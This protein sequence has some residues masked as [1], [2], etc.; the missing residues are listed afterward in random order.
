MKLS[1]LW[2]R[3]GFFLISVA[4]ILI[5]IIA[6][7]SIA[8]AAGTSATIT[9]VHPT[10][11]IDGSALA[12]SDIKETIITWRRPGD[13]TVVGSTRVPGPATTTVVSGL[14]C[15]S[16]NFTAATVVQTSSAETAPAAY[17]TG[18]VCAPNPPTG[19]KVT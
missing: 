16:F 17:A 11:Y 6:S 10:A 3:H 1:D 15:G 19:L 2:K 14:V 7:V 5:V 9:W 13:S 4:A 12:V 18:V 8:R